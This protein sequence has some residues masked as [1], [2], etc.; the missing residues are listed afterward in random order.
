M[1][2]AEY[3][4]HFSFKIDLRKAEG[5]EKLGQKANN[6][7]RET[8]GNYISSCSVTSEVTSLTH[9]P[10]KP[11]EGRTYFWVLSR[12]YSCNCDLVQMADHITGGL[13]PIYHPPEGI[14]GPVDLDFIARRN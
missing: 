13:C 1:C 10:G 14:H 2:I 9:T 6:R 8:T 3:C 7:K 4:V 11:E 5:E 12:S